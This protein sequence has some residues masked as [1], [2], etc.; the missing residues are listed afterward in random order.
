VKGLY[1]FIHNLCMTL[2]IVTWFTYRKL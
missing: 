1:S 2:W